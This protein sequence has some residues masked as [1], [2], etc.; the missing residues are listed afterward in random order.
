MKSSFRVFCTLWLVAAGTAGSP[1]AS[2]ANLNVPKGEIE[3][4]ATIVKLSDVFS[5]ISESS[6]DDIAQA[7]APCRQETYDVNVLTRLSDKYHLDWKARSLADHVVVSSACTRIP[8]SAIAAQV[9]KAVADKDTTLGAKNSIEVAFDN[10][11]LE[12]DLPADQTPGFA[13]NN[14]TY[15][16]VSKY[17]RADVVADTSSGPF[18]VP[19]TGRITIRHSVPVLA[20]RLEAGTIIAAS[21]I[22]WLDVP[23][24]HINPSVVADTDQ[25]IGR[26]LRRD[27]EG[28][29]MFHGHDVMPPRLVARGKLVTLKIETP[30]MMLTAEGKALQDGSA[31]DVVRVLNLQSDRVIEGTAESEGVV[32]VVSAQKVAEANDKQQ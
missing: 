4:R 32:R 5:G 20:H 16:P 12:I 13:L 14:F 9:K 26:A 17:F 3:V 2:A 22:D 28:G 18:A 21:D 23:E 1:A 6:D 19:V 25:L 8:A 29:E 31:G 10:H 30:F 11:A 7:P 27:T 24:D 15:D